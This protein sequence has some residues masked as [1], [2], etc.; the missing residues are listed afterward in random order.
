MENPGGGEGGRVLCTTVLTKQC[1]FFS[2]SRRCS[3][4]DWVAPPVYLGPVIYVEADVAIR[5]ARTF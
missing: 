4:L 3:Q 2:T 5:A 1:R